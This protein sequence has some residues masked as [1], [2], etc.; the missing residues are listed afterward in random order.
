[1]TLTTLSNLM[2]IDKIHP[3]K[4]SHKGQ[5]SRKRFLLIWR[6]FS[7]LNELNESFSWP[8]N[9]TFDRLCRTFWNVPWMPLGSKEGV[10]KLSFHKGLIKDWKSVNISIHMFFSV[11]YE[12][13]DSFS[14]HPTLPFERLSRSF[15][16]VP[17]ISS[18]STYIAKDCS[19]GS[20]SS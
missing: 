3:A 12:L 2:H 6:F 10:R 19:F 7:V 16:N 18:I 4:T 17:W 15:W 1:M 11:L 5:E 14:R 8:P 13:N 9:I 20:F